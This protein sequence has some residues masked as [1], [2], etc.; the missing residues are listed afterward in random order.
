MCSEKVV[1]LAVGWYTAAA[2]DSVADPED[3]ASGVKGIWGLFPPAGVQSP[4]CGFW[5]GGLAPIN[6]FCLMVSAFS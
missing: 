4:H 5:G 3:S 1:S 2:L 6:A